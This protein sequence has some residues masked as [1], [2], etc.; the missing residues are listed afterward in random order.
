MNFSKSVDYYDLHSYLYFKESDGMYVMNWIAK[1]WLE[2]LFGLIIG[3][4]G[5]SYK[6]LKNKVK[7]Q[8]DEQQKQICEQ[9]C[10]KNGLQA[11]LRDRIVQA[12]YKCIEQKYCPMYMLESINLMYKEYHNLGGNHFV[13]QLVDELME[14]PKFEPEYKDKQK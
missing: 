2:A 7:K 4:L 12:Y 14:M 5:L 8:L 1:Y 9:E 10:I 13:T 3:G 6:I 11:L